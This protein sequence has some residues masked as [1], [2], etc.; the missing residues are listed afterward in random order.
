ME[1][2]GRVDPA[3]DVPCGDEL[4]QAAHGEVRQRGDI[5]KR[6]TA[7]TSSGIRST[8]FAFLDETVDQQCKESCAKSP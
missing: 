1:S 3:T 5:A 7:D 6:A 8:F 2:K 4:A